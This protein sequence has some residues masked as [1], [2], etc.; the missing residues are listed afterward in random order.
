MG[1]HRVGD[2]ISVRTAD[3]VKQMPIVAPGAYVLHG[4]ALVEVAGGAGSVM[5]ADV[6]WV[7]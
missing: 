7:R 3:G 4:K 5:L 1:K 2:T 6:V